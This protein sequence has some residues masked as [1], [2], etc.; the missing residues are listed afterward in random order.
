MFKNHRL[1]CFYKYVFFYLYH[2]LKILLILYLK[3]KKTDYKKGLIINLFCDN[4]VLATIIAFFSK[5]RNLIK[6]NFIKN[7][8]FPNNIL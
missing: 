3:I 5:N 1:L 8:V 4:S 6:L 2:L 7:N